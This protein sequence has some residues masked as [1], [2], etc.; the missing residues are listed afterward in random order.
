MVY[1]ITTMHM[2]S[3]HRII[4]AKSTSWIKFCCHMIINSPNEIFNEHFADDML[5]GLSLG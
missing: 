5:S 1:L 4:N 3:N 2:L